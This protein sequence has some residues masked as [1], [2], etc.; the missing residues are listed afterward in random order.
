MNRRARSRSL[1]KSGGLND[2]FEPYRAVLDACRAA[3][4]RDLSMA[5]CYDQVLCYVTRGKMLRP[6]LVFMAASAVGGEPTTAMCGARAIELLH[7]ASLVHDDMIDGAVER[8]GLPALHLQLGFERALVVGDYL[9]L[10]SLTLV[11]Q[12]NG[13]GDSRIVRV[14]A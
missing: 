10:R 12:A 8:R 11:A 14:L 9:I 13:S 5:P 1:A 3:V 2:V 4:I 6:L 7:T